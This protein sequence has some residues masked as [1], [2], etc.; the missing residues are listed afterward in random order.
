M[1]HQVTAAIRRNHRQ[2][3]IG[4][5]TCLD[6]KR[7]QPRWHLTHKR[8]HI[9][10]ID[11]AVP[12]CVIHPPRLPAPRAI[13]QRVHRAR[14]SAAPRS[15]DLARSP[16]RTDDEHNLWLIDPDSTRKLIDAAL[17]PFI[18][19]VRA[20][21]DPN[22]EVQV[23]RDDDL[24]MWSAYGASASFPYDV[25]TWEVVPLTGEMAER[26]PDSAFDH[27]LEPWPRCPTHQDHPLYPDVR[28]GVAV[29][30]CRRGSQVRIQIG[31]L[32]GSA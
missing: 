1:N 17:A 14:T 24:W 25:E 27:V 8:D 30:V 10:E 20:T 2:V 21:L 22:F 16:A 7:T 28:Q 18:R 12:R 9:I 23:E 4:P 32:A 6:P 31:T 13:H 19:D 26:I 15:T 3:V 11:S 5:P 29:W